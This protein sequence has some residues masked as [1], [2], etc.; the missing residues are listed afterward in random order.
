MDYLFLMIG[1]LLLILVAVLFVRILQYKKQMRSFAGR[2]QKCMEE[3][4]NQTIPVEYFDRDILELAK[5]LNAYT[6]DIKEQTIQLEAERKQLKNVIAGISHD[7]R[8]PLT[9]AKGY[10]QLIEKSGTLDEKNAKYLDIAMSKTDYLRVL[11]DAFFE[12]SSAEAKEE[13]VEKQ[14]IPI[15]NFLTTRVLEQYDWINE[16]NIQAEFDIPETDALVCSNETM[17][18]RIVGNFF[19]NARKYAV[20]RIHIRLEETENSVVLSFENDIESDSE[21]DQ[22]HVFDAFYRGTSRQKE[23]AGLGLYVAKCLA[24]RLKHVISVT[25]LEQSFCICLAMKKVYTNL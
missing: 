16:N 1:G 15:A 8:T 18:N 17:L 21:M 25:V 10:M 24:E 12:V 20:S 19:S 7:F 13:A 2:I 9:S 22:N 6:Q 5:T 11:S 3:N 14:N 23:G 4:V